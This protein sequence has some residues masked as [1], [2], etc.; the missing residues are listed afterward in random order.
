MRPMF[1]MT[2]GTSA[3]IAE[4]LPMGMPSHL[5][6]AEDVGIGCPAQLSPHTQTTKARSWHGESTSKRA[7]WP[8]RGLQVKRNGFESQLW[9]QGAAGAAVRGEGDMGGSFG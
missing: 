8:I 7:I 5:L 3:N 6:S 4:L 2:A 9:L 1:G